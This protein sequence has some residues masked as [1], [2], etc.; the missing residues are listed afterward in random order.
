VTM[1]AA[2]VT[3]GAGGIGRA[4]ARRLA[5]TPYAVLAADL[6]EA[7]QACR[8]HPADHDRAG[9]VTDFA[10]DVR[11]PANVSE[12]VAAAAAL[13]ELRAVVCC[14]GVLRAHRTAD[15]QDDDLQQSLQ[16]NL[17]GAINVARATAALL[18][19]GSAIVMIGSIAAV[20][21]G[22]PGVAVYAASKA[23]LEGFTRALACELGPAGIRVNLVA[24]GFVR[25]P[26]SADLRSSVG[27]ER[28]V[29]QVPLGR[30]AEPEEVAD[31]VEFLLSER[32]SYVNGVVL[33]VDGGTTAR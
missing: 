24:P 15:L 6:P 17:A 12:A 10:L 19:P 26:M 16:V 14:A 13:G 3:G 18:L 20:R 31:V 7:L 33:P 27:T 1:A 30:L 23:G 9:T 28:L 2:L 32:A 29:R 4:V 22:A 21:G 11:S 5:A 25:A 8:A